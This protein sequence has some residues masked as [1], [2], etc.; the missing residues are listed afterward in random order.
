MYVRIWTW[1]SVGALL[2]ALP[3][4]NANAAQ[5][6]NQ[7]DRLKRT[8]DTTSKPQGPQ[9]IYLT[10][11]VAEIL[12]LNKSSISDDVIVAYIENSPS[13]YAVTPRQLIS[14]HDAGMSERVLKT[15][16]EHRSPMPEEVPAVGAP[17]FLS[18]NGVPQTS[19][20]SGRWVYVP[21]YGWYWQSAAPFNQPYGADAYSAPLIYGVV[22]DGGT[23]IVD[24]GHHNHGHDGDHHHDGG[25]PRPTP[26]ATQATG[27]GH[28]RTAI[29]NSGANP[30]L[31]IGG[32]IPSGN[33][34]PYGIAGQP[35]VANNGA[36]PYLPVGGTPASG[37]LPPYGIAGQPIVPNSGAYPYL[38]VGGT[39]ASGNLPPY[40]I[41][42]SPVVGHHGFQM[43]QFTP[44]PYLPAAPTLPSPPMLPSPPTLFNPATYPSPNSPPTGFFPPSPPTGFLP[45]S[46]PTGFST[47]A[48]RNGGAVRASGFHG[49][50]FHGGGSGGGGHR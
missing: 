35:L 23:V 21:S 15:L 6:T 17:P 13:D 24:D 39:P 22:S 25:H 2:L 43:A 11:K 45:L 1:L 20:P 14:L 48:M 36:Y 8:G 31:P 38:P 49:G 33:L 40:G 16:A 4:N 29:Q 32:Q 7:N 41:V 27:T 44:I 46:P 18:P 5:S 47:S 19:D 34:P 28:A 12:R 10:P 37:S 3:A 50:G 9:P 30:Y 26:H 42:Q